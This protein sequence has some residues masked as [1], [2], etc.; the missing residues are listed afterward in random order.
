MSSYKRAASPLVDEDEP[1]KCSKP[2]KVPVNLITIQ[3]KSDKE[4]DVY[5]HKLYTNYGGSVDGKCYNLSTTKDI[6]TYDERTGRW[7]VTLM[8]HGKAREMTRARFLVECLL[9]VE[10]IGS[11]QA[12]HIDGNKGNDRMDNLRRVSQADNLRFLTKSHIGQAMHKQRA[13]TISINI[14][15]RRLH[16]EDAYVEYDSCKSFVEIN[17]I[18]APSR[19]LSSLVRSAYKSE[20]KPTV[21]WHG[22]EVKMK[23]DPYLPGELWRPAVDRDGVTPITSLKGVSN[24]GRVHFKIGDRRTFGTFHDGYFYVSCN[25]RR[26]PVH[27]LIAAAWLGPIPKAHTVNHKDHN[28][29]NNAASN[30]DYQTVE[31]QNDHASG[32]PVVVT[33]FDG[34]APLT[35]PT[36]NK[37][38]RSLGIHERYFCNV[39]NGKKIRVTEDWRAVYI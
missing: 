28:S 15:A 33:F 29:K 35:F 30:L 19:S 27:N 18:T 26:L 16:S 1:S 10:S 37:A 3:L 7:T 9:A 14:L 36:A 5:Q 6:G 32:K 25:G 13:K 31:G 39:L 22:W 34:R 2:D 20:R 23:E 4:I 24:L 11:D 21:R 12:D 38:A 17:S 8:R